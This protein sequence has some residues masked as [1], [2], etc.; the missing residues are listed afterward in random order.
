MARRYESWGR[1]PDVV[2]RSVVASSRFDPFPSP[3]DD[4]SALPF[5]NGRSY[6]DCCL[7]D[8]GAVI[9][10]QRLDQFIAFDS[11]RGILRCESGVLLR[12]ILALSVSRGWFLPVT[13][14][15]QLVT[16]GGA[17]A[18]DVHGKN[19]HRA[20][21]FG[22][23][24][25]CFELLRSDGERREC[26]RDENS[27]LFNATVA[28]L[29][30]TGL[31]TWVELQLKPIATAMVD[32]E[33]LKFSSLA[34]FFHVSD[35]SDVRWEYTVAWVDAL[36]PSTAIGRGLFLR[37]NHA[38]EAEPAAHAARKTR[39]RM[40]I[41]LDVPGFVLNHYAMRVFNSTYYHRQRRKVARS[42]SDYVPFFYPLD[43][44]GDW[45][46]LYGKR[47]F[48]QFQCVV[49][50]ADGERVIG[51]ILRRV[52]AAHDGSFLSVLKVFGE[53]A[54]PGML[55]FPR[56][57][58]TLALDVPNH[59]EDT[60]RLLRELDALVCEAKGA[61]YPAKDATM[62]PESFRTYY[63]AWEEFTKHMDPACSSTFWRRVMGRGSTTADA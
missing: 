29:G 47:G 44:V 58:V 63:P 60:L 61:I 11:N 43:V 4:K 35:A 50:R 12:D 16:V 41:A 36:A 21:T 45:N 26:S 25:R 5:G 56:P 62:S 23:H 3:V 54:S 28:G 9:D 46:R 1:Y 48:F 30:L 49:P 17:V 24:V 42:Q 15:T 51:E 10:T 40:R 14:G 38:S 20:G 27:E 13:P 18:N 52:R 57:G 59:G 6:G 39:Q 33:S 8:R 2:Q 53:Q 37:G 31:I 34:E 22:C 32:V 19:H 7:N 55:S